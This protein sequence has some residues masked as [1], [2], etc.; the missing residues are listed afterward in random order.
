MRTEGDKVE[1][2]GSEVWARQG[3]RGSGVVAEFPT[4]SDR[5]SCRLMSIKQN[6]KCQSLAGQMLHHTEVNAVY[7]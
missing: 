5:Q 3:E 1:Q 2:A 7:E 4:W 6:H